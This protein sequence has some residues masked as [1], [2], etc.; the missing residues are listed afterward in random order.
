MQITIVWWMATFNTILVPLDEYQHLTASK[1]PDVR[2]Q[3]RQ[4]QL[5][6]IRDLPDWPGKAVKQGHL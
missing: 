2:P 1:H 3:P 5:E 6:L 4:Q